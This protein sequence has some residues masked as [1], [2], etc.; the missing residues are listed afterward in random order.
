[1][2]IMKPWLCALLIAVAPVAFPQAQPGGNTYVPSSGS[3]TGTVTSVAIAA[4]SIFTISGSPITTAGTLTLTAAGNSGGIP[5]FSSATA[6]GSSST[7]TANALLLGGGAG[8]VPTNVV[9]LGTTTTVLHGNSVGAPTFGS[10]SLT[11][12]VTNTLPLTSGGLGI[13]STVLGDTYYASAA[14]IAYALA[15]NTTTTK[16]FM[17]QTGTGSVSAAPAWG[18][19]ATGDLP[20]IGATPT[21][22]VG[23]TAISGSASTVIR[24]DGAPALDISIAP[25]WTGI[26]TWNNAANFNL[27]AGGGL[28]SI[29]IKNSCPVAEFY[30]TSA[31]TDAHRWGFDACTVN[32]FRINTV[33]DGGSGNVFLDLTRSSGLITDM[34]VGNTTA[35]P[36]TEFQGTGLITINPHVAY[37]GASPIVSA[38][39]T[40][41]TIDAHASDNTGTVNVGTV[42][43]AS[44]TVTFAS[45]FTTWNHCR[46]TSQSTIASFAYSY[47]LAAITVTGT[48]L[49]GDKFDYQCDG[50]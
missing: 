6:L 44:C 32:H 35:N 37:S 10:V 31:G 9:S 3:G 18:T 43:A 25:T 50:S 40:G 1:M 47:T 13:T 42:A 49:V 22:L 11:T 4:P 38:C 24:S 27:S 16:K 21:A 8:G 26:H 48:S 20:A 33:T 7:L 30:N 46:I 19:I 45:A 12:D 41:P 23:L 29:E 5:Y 34:K 36:T 17:I 28:N 39:G 2:R 15:G 14:N